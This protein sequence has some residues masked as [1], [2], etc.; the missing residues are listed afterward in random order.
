MAFKKRSASTNKS[1]TIIK[2]LR[3]RLKAFKLKRKATTNKTTMFGRNRSN[4]RRTGGFRN[5]FR[6]RSSF[7]QQ[8]PQRSY[9]G[10]FSRRVPIL[11]FK[12]PSLLIWV[13]IAGGAIFF[14]KDYIK[15][16]IDKLKHNN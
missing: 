14:G 9:G 13:A 15:P 5:P 4:R 1:M 16:L 8:R 12:L 10:G 6:G 3:L 11:G 7:R 2:R